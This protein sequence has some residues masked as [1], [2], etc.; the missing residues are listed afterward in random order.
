MGVEIWGWGTFGFWALTPN[1]IIARYS[2]GDREKSS[3]VWGR[4]GPHLG[5]IWGL[6]IWLFGAFWRTLA[7]ICSEL[8]R[9]IFDFFGG[10]RQT[11][12]PSNDAENFRKIK[13]DNFEQ[14][15]LEVGS[16]AVSTLFSR[17]R[18]P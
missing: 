8:C 2:P 5:E 17:C 10:V 4:I 3:F 11:H 6:E 7:Y 9:Q 15:A 16:I 14:C 12:V 13:F 1:L 18:R